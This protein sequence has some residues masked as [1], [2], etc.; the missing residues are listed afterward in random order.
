MEEQLCGRPWLFKQ[1]LDFFNFG[2]YDVNFPN[3][4]EKL[5]I[6]LEHLNL[7]IEEKGEDIAIK[8]MRKH[9]ACYVKS[10]RDASKIREKINIINNKQ[11]LTDCLVE[12]F[13][14]N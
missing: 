8:E 13:K 6:I 9:L 12:Y 1:I 3:N 7:A 5:K 11:E 2:E 14:T 4:E 10:G